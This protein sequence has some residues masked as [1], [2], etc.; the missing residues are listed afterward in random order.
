MAAGPAIVF[1]GPT[2]GGCRPFN[3]D[4]HFDFRPPARRGDVFRAIREA[5]SA[6]LLIDGYFGEQ[7]AIIHHELL[8]AISAG[9]TVCG[10]SS[11]GAL[12][13]AELSDV[14]M[15]GFGEVYRQYLTGALVGDDE[16][17]VLHSPPEL[18]YAP[19]TFA[20]VE[21]R[22]TLKRLVAL[23]TIDSDLERNLVK[24][25]KSVPFTLRTFDVLNLSGALG[26]SE[27][28]ALATLKKNWVH[29][30][31]QDALLAMTQVLNA[32]PESRS[33]QIR[34]FPLSTWT[35]EQLLD[36]LILAPSVVTA[37]EFLW[38]AA[39][40]FPDFAAIRRHVILTLIIAQH[41]T[42]CEQAP[43][44]F[45]LSRPNPD[46]P[47]DN[48][49]SPGTVGFDAVAGGGRDWLEVLDRAASVRD[50]C[51]KV[52][53]QLEESA[54]VGSCLEYSL[55]YEKVAYGPGLFEFIKSHCR[56]FAHKSSPEEASDFHG[57]S[58]RH[59]IFQQLLSSSSRDSILALAAMVKSTNVGVADSNPDVHLS[60]MSNSHLR[61]EFCN[62]VDISTN[63]LAG[64]AK[65]RGFDDV[66]DLT[67]AIRFIYLTERINR[68]RPSS[69][70]V[71]LL[72][73]MQSDSASDFNVH[74]LNYVAPDSSTRPSNQSPAG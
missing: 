31:R 1:S 28:T 63:D 24:I 39:M 26:I 41:A 3:L 15:L 27:R 34:T 4:A 60:E 68:V 18:D 33:L 71:D 50:A 49:L 30:K 17:A 43:D 57:L 74:R 11:I 46:Q 61:R 42:T 65:D 21:L 54:F 23:G 9:I 20:L 51:R 53:P 10:S 22:P 6:I 37:N 70:F 2:L 58:P 25:A 5:P 29:Q 45:A 35:T 64:F 16:V 73:R 66:G 59:Y 47:S 12:R 13:A 48:G 7:P 8:S 14:G 40:Y 55:R 19:L 67:E 62:W 36:S 69:Q 56:D 32:I 72:K 52:F 38:T 44:S